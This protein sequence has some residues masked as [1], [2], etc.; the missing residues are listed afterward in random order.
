[1]EYLNWVEHKQVQQVYL[2]SPWAIGI[3]EGNDK[4]ALFHH[5]RRYNKWSVVSGKTC[6]NEGCRT[7]PPSY[8]RT[9]YN[10]MNM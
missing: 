6:I 4:V 1:M 9:M 8:I 7:E 2:E 3:V 5:C 10:L